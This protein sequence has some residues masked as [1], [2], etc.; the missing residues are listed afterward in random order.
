[1]TPTEETAP[2]ELAEPGIEESQESPYGPRN[3]KLPLQLVNAIKATIKEFASQEL[4]VRRREVLRDRKNRFYERGYQ[5]IYEGRNGVF[6]Q[7]TPGGTISANGREI[8]CPAYIDDYNIYQPYLRIQE[9]ILT[10]NP[11][12]IDF[13]PLNPNR[14]ED[15]EASQ[16]AEGYRHVF[17]RSNNVKEIQTQIVRMLMLSGRVV[18][19]SRTE[20]MPEKFGYTDDNQPKQME[21]ATIHGTMESRVPILAKSQEECLFCFLYNDLDVKQAKAKYPGEGAD[22]IEF[23]SKIKANMSGLGES[24]YERLARLGVLNGSRMMSQIG[25]AFTHLATEQHDFLRPAAFTGDRFDDPLEEAGPEDMIEG[26]PLPT[27]GEKLRQLFP[28]GCRA[29]FVGDVYVGAANESMDDHLKILGGP[30]VGDGMFRM[31]GMDPMTVIQDRFNDNMNAAGEVWDHGWPSTWIHAGDVE[32]DSIVGQTA[33]PYAIRQLKELPNGMKAEDQFYR[34]PNPELPATF[35]QFLDFLEGPLAQFI[36]AAPPA[37]FGAAMQDQKTASGYA[38]ARA[39]AMGQQGL[40]WQGIQHLMAGMYY[41]AALAAAKNPTHEDEITFEGPD[42][43]TTTIRM[44]RLRKGKFGCYPDE[45]SSLPESTAA[46]RGTL[47]SILTMAAQSPILGAQIMESPDNWETFLDVFG[48]SELTIPEALSRQKAV[49]D[50]EK[51]L[52]QSPLPPSP[53][54]MQAAMVQHAAAAMTA[55][56]SG[57]PEP[58]TPNAAAMLKASIPVDPYAYFNWE[59]EKCKEWLNSDACRRQLEEGN[60]LGV[61]NVLLHWQE[62]QKMAILTAPPPPAAPAPGAG[63]HPPAKPAKPSNPSGPQKPATK[64]PA[65][66]GAPGADT[67]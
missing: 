27:V 16:T 17:D 54:E 63:A 6:L 25:D 35:M 36:M 20:E 11:P 48:F 26:Q 21:V 55:T 8:Q 47:A 22:G 10:Q 65:E 31:A 56:A 67:M 38:Q 49:S 5:H 37:L 28:D 57:Q 51:L 1:M 58:P 59:A 12:G 62:L 24:A 42:Q 64:P 30:Y 34:E 29:D 40:I 66:P 53:Q 43:Q 44:D 46:K 18:V 7:G 19:W 41:Q 13:R 45:D 15:T 33:S 2:E 23:A 4:F 52:Q 61:Q 14:P 9:A 3:E 32:Y 50:I 39:Q 60:Q